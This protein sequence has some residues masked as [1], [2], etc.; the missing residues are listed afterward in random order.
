MAT[1]VSARDIDDLVKAEGRR[2]SL[3]PDARL[4]PSAQDRLRE[5]G[6]EVVGGPA[7]P[8]GA[9]GHTA[10][11]NGSSRPPITVQARPAGD[12]AAA[13]AGTS[14]AE[15]RSQRAMMDF[16]AG[17]KGYSHTRDLQ[18]VYAQREAEFK[19]DH[20]RR[21]ANAAEAL[22]LISDKLA[23]RTDYFLNRVSQDMLWRSCGEIIKPHAE[24]LKQR[25]AAAE[26][27]GPGKL[28][29]NPN[30]QLPV[31]FS[32][33]EFHMMPGSYF[34]EELGG[35]FFEL[36]GSIYFSNRYD[37]A[38][39]QR[40][41]VDSTPSGFTPSRIL[42]MGCSIGTSTTVWKQRFPSAEVIGIDL[43][44]PMVRYAHLKANEQGLDVTFS[45]RNAEQ[46]GYP[47]ASFDLVTA[48]I[49]THELP[50]PAIR[51]VFREAYRLLR[52]G[53][54]LLNGDIN[55]TRI[56]PTTYSFIRA[57]WEVENNGEPYMNDVLNG[58][59]AQIARETGFR[60]VSEPGTIHQATGQTFPW[61]TLARK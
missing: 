9:N 27:E 40:A 10:D 14:V 17:L 34:D 36:G 38:R 4:T 19:R 51:N 58:D 50:I 43:G 45:Q 29:L 57:D 28:E 60:E 16:V 13:P 46:T 23:F 48:C 26:R 21:P 6:V 41:I 47:D 15:Q 33:T 37:G 25:L 49:L 2:I 35:F 18:Q 8:H 53:G 24:E 61:I 42:D 52:P 55:P 31:Y 39:M 11:R 56:H 44:A 3:P 32:G 22:A 12:K 20:G 59:L 1:L 54:Y 5:L 30:L 7:R